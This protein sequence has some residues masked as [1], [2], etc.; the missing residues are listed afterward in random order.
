MYTALKIP[1]GAL[2]TCW[3]T[4]GDFLEL[5]AFVLYTSTS[6]YTLVLVLYTSASSYTLILVLYTSTSS[7]TLVHSITHAR[8]K[9]SSSPDG[10]MPAHANTHA[11]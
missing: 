11:H 10:A 5:I 1:C 8:Q 7:Y 6:S 9:V 3:C 4:A 2:L